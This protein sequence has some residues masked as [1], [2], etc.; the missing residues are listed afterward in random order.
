MD[1][2]SAF[3]S[4]FLSL[5]SFSLSSYIAFAFAVPTKA[6]NKAVPNIAPP[7]IIFPYFPPILIGD[8]VGFPVIIP[9][10]ELNPALVKFFIPY[11]AKVPAATVPAIVSI[12]LFAK[13]FKYHFPIGELKNPPIRFIIASI[14]AT[15]LAKI[16][17][18]N[19]NPFDN[20]G[21]NSLLN[22]SAI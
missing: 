9:F 4:S 18:I 21:P 15:Y 20:C 12:G 6:P 3:C 17:S 5:I 13:L 22:L 14:P 11:L 1:T 2:N 10:N 7:A 19:G 16:A 8:F